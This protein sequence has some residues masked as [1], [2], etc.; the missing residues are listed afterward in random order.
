MGDILTIIPIST[1]VV[2]WIKPFVL[3]ASHPL[4][5]RGRAREG[6]HSLYFLFLLKPTPSEVARQL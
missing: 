4:S 2:W 1:E 3:S 6:E 5:H